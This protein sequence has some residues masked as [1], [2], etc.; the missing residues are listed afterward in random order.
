M[1]VAGGVCQIVKHQPEVKYLGLIEN[2]DELYNGI[3]IVVN[4]VRQGT[5]LKI[6]CLEAIAYGKPLVS[7]S[8]G[9]AGIENACNTVALKADTAK[10]LA[11][12]LENLINNS[13]LRERLQGNAA[14]FLESYNKNIIETLNTV[15]KAPK[16]Q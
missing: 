3:D 11:D 15:L 9:L 5:G 4:P 7:T 13:Q 8:E 1:L 12:H 16:R 6:K 14:S 2:L 10:T